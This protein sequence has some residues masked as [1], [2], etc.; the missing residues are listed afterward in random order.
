M[1]TG[2]FQAVPSCVLGLR[3]RTHSGSHFLVLSF[4]ANYFPRW[5]GRYVSITHMILGFAYKVFRSFFFWTY[6]GLTKM[7]IFFL[8]FSHC[9]FRTV[10]FGFI[11]KNIKPKYLDIFFVVLYTLFR[12]R[13][14][15]SFTISL[16]ASLSWGLLFFPWL[17]PPFHLLFIYDAKTNTRKPT[18]IHPSAR[19]WLFCLSLPPSIFFQIKKRSRALPFSQG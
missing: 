1:A 14:S 6:L 8:L 15:P 17:H 4:L 19:V 7:L 18:T 13:Y 10:F 3:P 16:P 11:C 12:S 9:H 2:K 5:N